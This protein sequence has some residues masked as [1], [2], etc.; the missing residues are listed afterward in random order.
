MSNIRLLAAV[1]KGLGPLLQSVVFVGGAVTELYASDSAATEVRA[2]DD[3][4][5]VV[6]LVSYR[7]FNVIEE[8]LRKLEF[9]NDTES[10]VICRWI[11][12]GIKVDI[13]PNDASVIGFTNQWYA[14]GIRNSV[15][16]ELEEHLTI[17]IFGPAWFLASKMVA[18]ADRGKYDFRTSSDFEDII[19]V[20]DNKQ[21]IM[22]DIQSADQNVRYYLKGEFQ[23]YL[24]NNSL[25]EG[26]FCALPYASGKERIDRIKSI[27][28]EISSLM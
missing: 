10:T 16:F 6:E 7:E 2:T 21:S 26:I 18:F 9:K 1:A 27:M 22:E 5:C 11:Y 19:Y 12:K 15:K 8:E 24:S 17:R 20:L 13:M 3:V 4:D 14:E 25:S 28:E 23:K